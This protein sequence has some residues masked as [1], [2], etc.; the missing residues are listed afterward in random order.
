MKR[1]RDTENIVSW[2]SK[3]LSAEKL[4]TSATTDNNLC[5]LIK[6]YGNFCIAFKGNKNS[7][8]QE[9]R[10]YTP[11]NRINFFIVYGLDAWS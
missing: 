5:P 4:T 2:K 10:T 11:P 3:G 8:K 6:W 9:N 1:L 7:L